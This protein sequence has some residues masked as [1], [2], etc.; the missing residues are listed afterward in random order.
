[1]GYYIHGVLGRLRV[2][3]P[4]VKSDQNKADEVLRMLKTVRGVKFS[5]ANTRTGSVLL[6]YDRKIISEKEIV[7]FLREHGY[8]NESKA[9]TN[10]HYIQSALT[11]A[12]HV[13]QKSLFGALVDHAFQGSAF[14]LLSAFL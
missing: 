4:M 1:M 12:G 13:V 14:S 10:D 3:T 11:K 9:V 2:K 6:S 8:F 7:V 5:H